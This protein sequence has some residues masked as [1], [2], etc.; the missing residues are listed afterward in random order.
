M[1]L[2]HLYYVDIADLLDVAG[3][4][5]AF[6]ALKKKNTLAGLITKGQLKSLLLF[7][8][9]RKFYSLAELGK[10]S[11]RNPVATFAGSKYT[12]NL[13]DDN[14]SIRVKSTW[15]NA[16]IVSCVYARA[17]VA[18]Y[19]VDKVLLPMQIFS[20]Q[21]HVLALMSHRLPPSCR[22]ILL[23]TCEVLLRT[24][25]AYASRLLDGRHEKRKLR[26][27]QAHTNDDE[28]RPLH[29]ADVRTVGPTQP[30]TKNL[31]RASITGRIPAFAITKPIKTCPTSPSHLIKPNQSNQLRSS[32]LSP[33]LTSPLTYNN[34]EE[35]IKMS[36]E[37]LDGSTVRSFV[38]DECLQLHR[39]RPVSPRWTPTTDGLLSYSEMA[40]ELMS[41]RESVKPNELAGV[42]RGLFAAVDRDEFR[43][44]MKE[45][46][47]AVANGLGFLPVQMVVEEGSFLKIAVDRELG[48]LAKAA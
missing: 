44:E 48:Q 8:A 14:G 30:P 25:S 19:E 5:S 26:V 31:R 22:H 15:S 32:V 4:D 23:S 1:L 16:K 21:A 41:L 40:R 2:F 28:T 24:D 37:I 34:R 38:E 39:R 11:R 18:V 3:P 45:V 36:V 7:H 9:F 29:L 35:L 17:P 10:L 33:L 12:L 20:S 13:T 27:V 47:L 6:A 42:Y 43:A 46:M